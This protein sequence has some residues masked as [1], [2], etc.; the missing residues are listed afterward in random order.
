M[1]PSSVS[2]LQQQGSRDGSQQEFPPAGSMLLK[3]EQYEAF[4]LGTVVSA[5]GT[6]TG[7]VLSLAW[8]QRAVLFGS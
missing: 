3:S 1:L 4:L 5:R 6:A 2:L 8:W 7:K